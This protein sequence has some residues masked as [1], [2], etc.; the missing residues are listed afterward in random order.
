VRDK[1]E[2]ENAFFNSLIKT[3]NKEKSARR[4]KALCVTRSL[5]FQFNPSFPSL[6]PFP[7]PSP[8]QGEGKRASRARR[9]HVACAIPR[10]AFDGCH[11]ADF[12]PFAG[13]NSVPSY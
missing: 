12:K 7:D 2:G 10:A 3:Q 4:K 6:R 8:F 1:S 13:L 9:A 5:P 11:S